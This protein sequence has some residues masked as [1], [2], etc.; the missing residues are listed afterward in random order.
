MNKKLIEKT[1]YF[2]MKHS[3]LELVI[4]VSLSFFVIFPTHT[5]A[6]HDSG[7]TGNT[8]HTLE[9]VVVT[10]KKISE[11]IKNHPQNILILDR[12]EIKERNF[13]ELEEALDS[14]PGVDVRQLGGGM[15]TRISIR[16]SGGSGN[17]LV[18]VNGKPVNSGLYG[19]VELGSI[20]IDIVKKVTVFKPPVPVWL[21][22]GGTAGAIN[23]ETSSTLETVSEGKKIRNRLKIN[24]GSFGSAN[25]SY[26]FVVP[27][28]YGS[29]MATAGAGHKDGKRANSDRDSGNFSFHWDKKKDNFTKYDFNGRYFYSRHGSAGPTDNPTPDA[30]QRYN[31]GALDFRIKGLMG[32]TGDFSF[33]SYMD[34]E[35]LKDESQTGETSDLDVYKIGVKGDYNWA[36]EGDKWVMRIGGMVEHNAVDHT[37]SGDHHR[38]KL[39]AHTQLDWEFDDFT[40]I[41]GLRGDYTSDFGFFPAVST[42]LSCAI[43]P[44]SLLKTNIGYSVKVPTFGQ[45]Y[46]PSHGSIDQVRGNP[47]L[48]EEKVYAYDLGFEHKFSQNYIFEA[49][50]F[51][52][53]THDLI[54]YQR[55]TDLIYRPVNIDR[56]YRQGLEI[57]FKMKLSSK[58]SVDFNYIFQESKNEETDGELTYTPRHKGKITGKYILGTGTRLEAILRAVGD[59]YSDPENTDSK[60]LD[61]YSFI[62]LKIIHPVSIKS[63][64]GEVFVNFNN[65]F[66]TDFEIHHGYPDDGFRFVSGLNLNF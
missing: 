61:A 16:G 35:D 51:R 24:G 1:G 43:G 32:E 15:G 30:R 7:L 34:V 50:L 3:I 19:N 39:S 2:F 12:Q 28:E 57:S 47:D 33:K 46:Q 59:Q 27:Q 52:T 22:P 63:I 10:A 45:L 4:F 42:G 40:T 44:D 41:L 54:I 56:A 26:S 31:K 17:V 23:I 48:S 60:K 8:I 64:S 36:Q 55:G 9:S 37:L 20:P 18:L 58:A 11:Y 14:M 53:D 38:E 13:L 49:T 21:G 25:M 5:L 62:D 29:I 65:L 66:D 6:Q